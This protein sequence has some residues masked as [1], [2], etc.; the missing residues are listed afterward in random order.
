MQRNEV[1]GFYG[2]EIARLLRSV[3]FSWNALLRGF[4]KVPLFPNTR[5]NRIMRQQYGKKKE[6]KTMS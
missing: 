5:E 2:M 4:G 3:R 6:R 1:L